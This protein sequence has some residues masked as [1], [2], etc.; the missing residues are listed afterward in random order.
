MEATLPDPRVR[1]A[2]GHHPQSGYPPVHKSHPQTTPA[3]TV[4]RILALSVAHPEWGCN[5]ISDH[6]KLDGV[7]LSSVTVQNLLI[8]NNLGSRYE[9]LLRLEEK[10]TTEQIEL[11][12]AQIAMIE[13]ANPVF[14]ER[15]VES[16]RP[17]ELLSQDVFYR[18]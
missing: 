1:G 18:P 16:S 13:K 14:K 7:N 4:E 15:H 2:Q 9:R 8:K 11:T 5:R 6:L 17:G 10:A 3:E 12:T